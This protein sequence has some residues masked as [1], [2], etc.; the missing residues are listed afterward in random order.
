MSLSFRQLDGCHI[1]HSNHLVVKGGD[2]RREIEIEAGID[3][4][5]DAL[6][7]EEGRASWLDEEERSILVESAEPPHRLVW[8]WW[9]ED[10]PATRVEFLV[11]RAVSTTRVVVI[12]SSPSSVLPLAS[13][14]ARFA[15]VA[16]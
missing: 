8:W 4:V 16:A 6:A 1:E 5:W 7:S 9:E 15:L 12:E 11:V 14:S 10:G 13:L 3:E 2:V